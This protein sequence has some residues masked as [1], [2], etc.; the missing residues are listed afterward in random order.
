MSTLSIFITPGE[1]I[2]AFDSASLFVDLPVLSHEEGS[3]PLAQLL[4]TLGQEQVHLACP[5]AEEIEVDDATEHFQPISGRSEFL[6]ALVV[7]KKKRT[8]VKNPWLVQVQ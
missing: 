4:G 3:E 6:D 8:E 1:G 5:E 2:H 7:E